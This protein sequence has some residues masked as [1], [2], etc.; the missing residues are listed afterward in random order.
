MVARPVLRVI[1][2]AST[3]L[4]PGRRLCWPPDA[5]LT[6][7]NEATT[8]A[9]VPLPTWTIPAGRTK[10]HRV[11]AVPLAAEALAVI[12]ELKAYRRKDVE[13]V[14]STT[15]TPVR[16]PKARSSFQY[17]GLAERL[18][19]CRRAVPSTCVGAGITAR[20]SGRTG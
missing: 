5:T 20:F 18:T 19:V 9:G 8:D 1:S 3:R 2:C 13:L 17:I 4:E 12:E 15:G 16:S 7:S 11:H 14:F 10:A 6:S